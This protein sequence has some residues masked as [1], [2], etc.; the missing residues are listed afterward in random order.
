MDE[1]SK[2]E[3]IGANI[4]IKYENNGTTT[5]LDGAF[6]ITSNQLPVSLECSYIGYQT[7]TIEVKSNN[8][9]IIIK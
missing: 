9:K 2:E 3:L 6:T 5:D 8:Q 4:I 7:Q 1:N